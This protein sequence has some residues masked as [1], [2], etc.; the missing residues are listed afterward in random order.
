ML[1]DKINIMDQDLY[2][3]ITDCMNTSASY[4]LSHRIYVAK[5]S[6]SVRYFTI[7]H[8]KWILYYVN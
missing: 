8:I 5:R 1:R 2:S 6:V 4:E 3:D 7:H